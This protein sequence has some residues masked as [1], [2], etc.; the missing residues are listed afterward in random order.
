ML[1][2][3]KELKAL[4]EIKHSPDE[5]LRASTRALVHQEIHRLQPRERRPAVRPTRR[6]MRWPAV[7]AAAAAV[8][9]LAA[10]MLP[11]VQTAQAAGYYTVDINPSVT[12]SVD[13]NDVVLSAAAG[14]PDA[15][16]LLKDTRL[17]GLPISDALE[18]LVRA[19]STGGW[20][21]DNGHVLVAHFGDTPGISEQQAAD[22]IR[23]AAGDTVNVLVLQSSKDDYE[24]A[25]MQQ[26]SAGLELLKK[27]AHSLGVDDS[28]DVDDMITAVDKKQKQ[29]DSQK[30]DKTNVSEKPSSTPK[31]TVTPG[32][33]NGNGGKPDNGKGKD[34][35]PDKPDDKGKPD[36]GA[37]AEPGKKNQT[38]KNNSK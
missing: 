22:I 38:G 10:L 29:Q 30:Q 26:R 27:N 14:N 28:L 32:Q 21:S 9:L 12:L 4:S 15:A 33:N 24:A 37:N 7:A 2:I 19:A 25:E 20:L 11:P 31:P 23:G 17:T 13:A 16:A 34:N 36:K 3:D 8:I 35:K 6:V 1:D 18:A 5:A